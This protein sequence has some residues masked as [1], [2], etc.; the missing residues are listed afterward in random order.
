MFVYYYLNKLYV[1]LNVFRWSS[2]FLRSTCCCTG[3]SGARVLAV[4]LYIYHSE[5]TLLIM[6]QVIQ[7]LEK[8]T[9]AGKCLLL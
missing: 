1:F 6:E 4:V 5:K 3:G 2:V 8:T 7:I 9:S